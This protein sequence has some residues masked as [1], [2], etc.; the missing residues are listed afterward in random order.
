MA[1][2]PAFSEPQSDWPRAPLPP[3]LGQSGGE[4][5]AAEVAPRDNPPSPAAHEEMGPIPGPC[6][7]PYLYNSD[8]PGAKIDFYWIDIAPH[9]LATL[10]PRADRRLDGA[11]RTR[12]TC[13]G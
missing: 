6:I 4:A 7:L 9:G 3:F 8:T 11:R 12:A 5:R 10:I 13:G 2:I 1:F